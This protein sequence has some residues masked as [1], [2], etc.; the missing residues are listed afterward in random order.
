MVNGL[1][2][3]LDN[4]IYGSAGNDGG[5]I[6][7]K[8]KDVPP[9]SLRGRGLR[10]KPWIPGSLEPTSG[11]GQF[12]LTTD[13]YQHWFT[14]PTLSTSNTSSC[15]NHYLRRNPYLPVSQVT[16]NIPE[17]GAAAKVFES[18]RSSS[19]GSIA[20]IAAQRG[21]TQSASPRTNSCPAGFITSCE[22]PLIYTPISSPKRTAGNNFVCDPANT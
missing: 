3:G 9:V 15:R 20:R 22:H 5:T 21:R 19:G 12:G 13:D 18:A 14:R 4:W 10:F 16:I 17:H 2:W 7:S 11:G 6:T 1:Q 8:E